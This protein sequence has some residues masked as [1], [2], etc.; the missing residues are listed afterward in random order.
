MDGRG[1]LVGPRLYS[2][3]IVFTLIK[4]G[5][6]NCCSILNFIVR[7]RVAFR[8]LFYLAIIKIKLKKIGQN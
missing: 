6:N 7:L 3:I 1:L 8:A 2:V 5:Q 4:T